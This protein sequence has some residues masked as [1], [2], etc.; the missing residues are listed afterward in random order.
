MPTKPT[1]IGNSTDDDDD[2]AD[3]KDNIDSDHHF[4]EIL[5]IS[6]SVVAMCV[7]VTI[8][9]VI[10]YTSVNKRRKVVAMGPPKPFTVAESGW[11][12][13]SLPTH[14]LEIS[15]EVTYNLILLL[16]YWFKNYYGNQK[17]SISVFLLFLIIATKTLASIN[18]V[19]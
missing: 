13:S 14:E 1:N 9:I 17:T 5:T 15:D 11:G 2:D 3:D 18:K 7:A 16:S 10:V 12:Y 19:F 4:G 8:V 6:I